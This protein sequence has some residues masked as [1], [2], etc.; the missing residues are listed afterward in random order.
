MSLEMVTA[1]RKSNA[2]FAFVDSKVPLY[3]ST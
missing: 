3:L 2:L 1:Y